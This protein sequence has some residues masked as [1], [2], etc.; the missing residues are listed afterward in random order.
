MSTFANETEINVGN[1]FE[2]HGKYGIISA[3]KYK[4]PNNHE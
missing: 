2:V 1:S 4:I 3:F